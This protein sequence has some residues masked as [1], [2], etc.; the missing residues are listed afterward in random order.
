M[1]EVER[2]PDAPHLLPSVATRVKAGGA[3]EANENE[4]DGFDESSDSQV[5]NGMNGMKSEIGNPEIPEIRNLEKSVTSG[6]PEMRKSRK[7]GEIR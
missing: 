4:I 3:D 1:G 6:N 5:I 2:W 7:S